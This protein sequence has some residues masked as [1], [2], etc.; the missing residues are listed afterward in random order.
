MIR[1][2][3]KIIEEDSHQ[4]LKSTEKKHKVQ[5]A[6]KQKKRI[7]L[8]FFSLSGRFLFYS[9]LKKKNIQGTQ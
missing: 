3:L 4:S 1:K 9:C 8:L 6:E 2:D 5:T 7:S